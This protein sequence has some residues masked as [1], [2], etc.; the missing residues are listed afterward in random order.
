MVILSSTACR[1]VARARLQAR[2]SG[3]AQHKGQPQ[4]ESTPGTHAQ[5][6][7][8]EHAQHESRT[9]EFEAETSL[10]IHK[11]NAESV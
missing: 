10:A 1:A 5:Q 6:L 9:E 11:S 4:D 8:S 2:Q 3:E 7:I